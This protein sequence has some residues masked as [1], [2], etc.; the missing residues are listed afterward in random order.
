MF[1][2]IFVVS[3]SILVAL[4]AVQNA[5]T[6]PLNFIFW[7]FYTSLV[8]V[9]IGSFLCGVL[10]AT[11]FLLIVKARHY[12][13]DKKMQEEISFLKQEVNRLE[14][15]V[16]VLRTESVFSKEDKSVTGTEQGNEGIPK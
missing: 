8:L 7:N 11:C 2:L 4:F 15:K 5:I 10:V 3:I 16:A 12:L 1:L 14:N 13:H 6:V 9:I